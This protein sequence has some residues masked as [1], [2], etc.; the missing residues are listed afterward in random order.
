MLPLSRVDSLI[1][2]HMPLTASHVVCWA[3]G[4]LDKEDL[5]TFSWNLILLLGGGSVLGA[6]V[7]YVIALPHSQH[8]CVHCR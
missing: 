1:N 6:A 4:I 7:Q 8:R 3:A 2:K 5:K